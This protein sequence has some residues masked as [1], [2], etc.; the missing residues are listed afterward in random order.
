MASV[1]ISIGS[2]IKNPK[3]QI[4][5]AFDQIAALPQTQLLKKS[6]LSETLPWGKTDQPAFIN[7]AV[8]VE[9]SLT[10]IDLLDALQGIENKAGRTREVK[11][12]PRTLDLDIIHYEGVQRN[13]ARLTLPHSLFSEREFVLEPLVEIDPEYVI[14]GKSLSQWLTLLIKKQ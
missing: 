13:S 5:L 12:G 6:S 14:R 9:T 11:W 8:K 7:A 2:N 4:T 3:Q 10:P 1:F